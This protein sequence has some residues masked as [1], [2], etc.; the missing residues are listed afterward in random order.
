MRIVS[1]ASR[2]ADAIG[3][4][5]DDRRTLGVAVGDIT[6]LSA[7]TQQAVTAHLQAQKPEGWFAGEQ[8]DLAWTNGN[9]ALPLPTQHTQGAICM[10]S[11]K[12]R[13]AGPYLLTD[14]MQ[15]TAAKTA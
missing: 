3:P 14:T 10:L 1:R 8:A 15:N 5:V 9:A 4:F 13:A 2:P 12:I 6:L 7:A 11:V